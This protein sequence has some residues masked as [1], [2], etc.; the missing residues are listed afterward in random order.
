MPL[1]ES[2]RSMR[3]TLPWSFEARTWSTQAR[4]SATG[5]SEARMPMSPILGSS[6]AATQSQSTD[7]L[8]ATLMY[9][10]LSPQWSVIALAASAMDSRKWSCGGR[11]LHTSC[12]LRVLPAECIH[13]L[14]WEEA[15]PMAMFLMAPPKPPMGCPLKWE[16]TRV[17]S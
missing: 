6:G 12:W 10:M 16:S 13:A 8:L 3:C 15:M 1:R 14:P 17:K 5:S 2:M 11:S 7:R 9:R 4:S